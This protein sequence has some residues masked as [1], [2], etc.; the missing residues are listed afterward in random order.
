MLFEFHNSF[1]FFLPAI[2]FPIHPAKQTVHFSPESLKPSIHT[3]CL[4]KQNRYLVDPKSFHRKL[5]D[6]ADGLISHMEDHF[7]VLEQVDRLAQ[8]ELKELTSL[9]QNREG[10]LL[11]AV[12]NEASQE[13]SV[14]NAAAGFFPAQIRLPALSEWSLSD[15]LNLI[16]R[17]F[18]FRSKGNLA[19]Q[20]GWYVL[21]FCVITCIAFV[22]MLFLFRPVA[23]RCNSMH[24]FLRTH[25]YFMKMPPFRLSGMGAYIRA[26]GGCFKR[27]GFLC[28]GFSQRLWQD[29]QL[30]P[31]PSPFQPPFLE[32]HTTASANRTASTSRVI[33]P[34]SVNILKT[35]FPAERFRLQYTRFCPGAQ[36]EC[37]AKKIE[38]F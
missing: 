29:A 3:V 6:P 17:N 27:Y 18:V 21:A 28:S 35:S 11:A 12:I 38:I 1:T 33:I 32:I 15:R 4:E 36:P 7:I 26:D 2:P 14:Q 5:F 20:I 23:C 25:L 30:P 37:R 22:G 19:K 9:L 8:G 34:R 10:G 24:F 13:A 31:Q 16:R